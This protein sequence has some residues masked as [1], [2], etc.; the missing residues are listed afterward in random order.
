MSIPA[1]RAFA[2]LGEFLIAH[3]ATAHIVYRLDE[4]E[5]TVRLVDPTGWGHD[6]VLSLAIAQALEEAGW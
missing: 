5:W 6:E 3:E 1:K 2:E 4:S